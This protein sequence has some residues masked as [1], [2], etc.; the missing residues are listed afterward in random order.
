GLLSGGA[1]IP[2]LWGGRHPSPG[3]PLRQNPILFRYS[4]IS[5]L[6]FRTL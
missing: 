2:C 5:G 4:T 3:K 1:G 6:H